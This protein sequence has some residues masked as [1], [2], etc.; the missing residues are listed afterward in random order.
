MNAR[1]LA[2]QAALAAALAA[3]VAGC[4]LQSPPTRDDLKR[5]TLAHTAV[6][7]AF[8][9]GD[10]AAK[11]LPAAWLATFDDPDLSALVTEALAHNADLRHRRGA[12]RAGGR[13]AAGRQRFAA[14]VARRSP[15]PTAA[16]PAAAAG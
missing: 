14:A 10:M 1:L 7:G 9:A 2:R 15:A 13:H 4:A 6:P 12:C 11:P 8:K 16:R 5:D 3:G